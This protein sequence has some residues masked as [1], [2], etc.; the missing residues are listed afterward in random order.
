[1]TYHVCKWSSE[2]FAV[3]FGVDIFK[4]MVFGEM[5]LELKGIIQ[6]PVLFRLPCRKEMSSNY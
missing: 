3:L 5:L 4:I 1:M 6:Q 2:D